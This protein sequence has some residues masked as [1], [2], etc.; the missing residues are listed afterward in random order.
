M[1]NCEKYSL[2]FIR[3]KNK[4][5]IYPH[6]VPPISLSDIHITMYNYLKIFLN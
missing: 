2:N 1:K 3:E 4:S 6:L 5:V